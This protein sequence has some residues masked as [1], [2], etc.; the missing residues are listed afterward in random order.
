M[1][2]R[3]ALKYVR[4]KR[5]RGARILRL[6]REE[7]EPRVDELFGILKR[8]EPSLIVI[9]EGEARRGF[10]LGIETEV[11]ILRGIK[12]E[13]ARSMKE[14]DGNAMIQERGVV[15]H[16]LEQ[17]VI[18]YFIGR[19][20]Q[21]IGNIEKRRSDRGVRDELRKIVIAHNK[22]LLMVK[23]SLDSPEQSY[24]YGSMQACRTGTRQLV[25]L[26]PSR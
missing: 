5:G 16:L 3:T 23:R 7:N 13:N 9:A 15:I 21:G 18:E 2:E 20:V 8:P 17:S 22:H 12:T 6:G 26:Q 1:E 19:N 24:A 11:D 4:K 14:L 25:K 10:I